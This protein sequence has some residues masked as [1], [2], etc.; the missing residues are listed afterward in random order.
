MTV[1]KATQRWTPLSGEL[2]PGMPSPLEANPRPCAV[3]ARSSWWKLGRG[4]VGVGSRPF[5]QPAMEASCCEW[6]PQDPL[7]EEAVVATG[8]A[9]QLPWGSDC[10]GQ[11]K[12]AGNEEK[13]GNP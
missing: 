1:R 2:A 7:A 6:I 4:R 3:P 9:Q 5:W 12:E 11:E 10:E 8:T 13:G